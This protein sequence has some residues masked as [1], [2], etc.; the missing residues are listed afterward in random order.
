M[1]VSYTADDLPSL[2][3]ILTVVI[4]NLGLTPSPSLV[5]SFEMNREKLSSSSGIRSSNMK[6]YR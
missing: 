4:E 3:T 5:S 1:N 6:W 2:S